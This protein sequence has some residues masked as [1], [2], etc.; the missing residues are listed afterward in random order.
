MAISRSTAWNRLDWI[1]LARHM[2]TSLQ[3]TGWYRYFPNATGCTLI[4]LPGL[5]A[6]IKWRV[7]VASRAER[8]CR[9]VPKVAGLAR[10]RL[11]DPP[12]PPKSTNQ[13]GKCYRAP[14]SA[15]S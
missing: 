8:V 4:G 12:L 15:V 10:A 9:C 3:Q 11:R 7:Q 1:S 13:A 5:S 2:P 14:A 6:P